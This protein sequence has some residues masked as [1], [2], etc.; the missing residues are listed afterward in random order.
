MRW[1]GTQ[2][3]AV[4]R[5]NLAQEPGEFVARSLVAA[6]MASGGEEVL[7]IVLVDG[8]LRSSGTWP[9]RADLAGSVGF[10]VPAPARRRSAGPRQATPA[11]PGRRR[12]RR[13]LLLM[14][15]VGIPG[16]VD[17]TDTCSS[18]Q[19]RRRKASTACATAIGLAGLGRSVLLVSTD[20]ASNLDEVLGARIGTSPTLIEAV[21]GLSALNVDPEA[22]AAAYRERVIGPTA[23]C[24]PTVP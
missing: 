2:G 14:P 12:E 13:Q 3:V 11:A 22:A 21:P 16:L 6:M 5:H 1:L 10:T 23:E 18:R 17:T 4:T 8:R 24:C 7:P 20:P 9:T 19:R 15:R